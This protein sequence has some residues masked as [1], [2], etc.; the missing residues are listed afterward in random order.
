[1]KTCPICGREFLPAVQTIYKV[2]ANRKIYNCC[3]YTCWEEAKK[4]KKAGTLSTN[5]LTET[6]PVCYN[7]S[8]G[9]RNMTE[10]KTNTAIP[11]NRLKEYRDRARLTLQEVS[12][13]TGYDVTTICKHETSQR[14]MTEE[15]IEKYASLYKVKT[16][17]LFV[18]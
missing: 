7:S 4:R 12:I 9:E 1:M 2:K 16:H 5:T 10:S 14:R 17:E 11:K 6:T 15:A 3:G 8:G 18:L 13:L